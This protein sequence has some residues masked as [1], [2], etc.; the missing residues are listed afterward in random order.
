T[1]E[2]HGK[3]VI[4]VRYPTSWPPMIERGV[5][6]DGYAC[7]SCGDDPMEIAP[8]LCYTTGV[9]RLSQ[10]VEFDLAKGWKNAPESAL[11]PIEAEIRITPKK[12]WSP[13]RPDN[14]LIEWDEEHSVRY[15]ALLVATTKEGYDTLVISPNKDAA[16]AVAT[17]KEG[18]WSPWITADFR[19]RGSPVKGSF[20]FKL[21]EL[22]R[23]ARGFALYRSQVY[24]VEGWAYPN[25]VCQELIEKVGYF[26]P[27]ASPEPWASLWCDVTLFLEEARDQAMWLA[28]AVVYLM[29][30]K[31]GDLAMLQWHSPDH[32]KHAWW[33]GLDPSSPSYD[34]EK[35]DGYWDVMERDYGIADEMIG[36]ILDR[37]DMDDT[38]V[39]VVS[40]HGHVPSLKSV[41]TNRALARAGLLKVKED[42]SI[43]WEE[44]RAVD[45]AGIW[46]ISRS[47]HVYVNLKG[48]DPTGVVEPGEE[49]EEVRREVISTLYGIRDPDTGKCPVTMALRREDAGII[50]LGG[51]RVGDVVYLL[52][53]EYH[54]GTAITPLDGPL[55]ERVTVSTLWGL[56]GSHHG[57]SLPTARAGVGTHEAV[58]IACGSGIKRGY[59]RPRP[60]S[61]RDVAPTVARLLGIPAPPQAQG[62]PLYDMLEE[63]V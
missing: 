13:F 19:A 60:V 48:R 36:Y 59:R 16:L 56:S 4:L 63:S 14:K 40:D 35:A 28:K 20:R 32:C 25:P 38:A 29:G 12:G 3:R 34:P 22:T 39:M 10:R 1:A 6:V 8:C 47:V 45:Q 52:E 27:Q 46:G 53:P 33:G 54:T 57:Q 15:H 17:L 5:V 51:D 42:G 24:P 55:V 44:T 43:D 9:G 50:G 61:L 11:P 41:F 7:P 58:F 49:Y 2:R 30:S 18:G 26:I 37:V 23:D 21:M 31:G 62:I